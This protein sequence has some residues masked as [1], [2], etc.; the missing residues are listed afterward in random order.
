MNELL[1][2]YCEGR[3]DLARLLQQDLE[4]AGVAADGSLHDILWSNAWESGDGFDIFFPSGHRRRNEVTGYPTA[5]AEASLHVQDRGKWFR[6]QVTTNWVLPCCDYADFD[7]YFSAMSA[8]ARKNLKYYDNVYNR[9]QIRI[10]SIQNDDDMERFLTLF[11]WQWPQSAFV[12]KQKAWFLR[13]YR[14]LREKAWSE[15]YIVVDEDG[16][17]AAACLGYYT[18]RAFNLHLLCRQDSTLDKYS[19]GFY[20][21][22]WMVRRIMQERRVPAFIFGPG[23]FDYKERFLAQ[24]LPVY[25]YEQKGWQNI[26]GCLRLINRARKQRKHPRR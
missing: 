13:V 17:D 14:F 12:G 9:K 22:Y 10:E 16:R 18:A 8:K 3:R 4:E 5:D 23:H 21:T 1:N 11:A 7:A 24:Y 20:L 25:R 15:G 2:C 26:A 6:L 19:P